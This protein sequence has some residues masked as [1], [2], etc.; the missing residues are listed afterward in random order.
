MK[1]LLITLAIGDK[2]LQMYNLLFRKSQENYAKKYGYDF[3]VLDKFISSETNFSNQHPHLISFQKILVCSQ[4]FSSKYDII[5]F[6]DADILI[7]TNTP[8]LHNLKDWGNNIGIVDEYSQ[9]TPELRIQ[10]QKNNNWETT[11]TDYYKLA[12]LDINTNKLLNTGVLV[13]QPKKHSQFLVNIYNKYAKQAI[14]HFR[15]FNYEQSCIG[16]ELQINNN[17]ILIDN[18][19]NALWALYKNIGNKYKTLQEI[20]NNNYFIHFA[21]KCDIHLVNQIIT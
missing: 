13:M 8:P 3:M 4:S 15:G 6:I 18:K 5:I 20:Y 7:N 17:Y 12:G 21:G 11:A 2:Y 9:P 14:N 10:L 1:I 16:Y 19:W